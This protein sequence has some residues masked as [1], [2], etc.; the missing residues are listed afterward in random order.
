MTGKDRPPGGDSRGPEDI[1]G[2]NR[3]DV[4]CMVTDGAHADPLAAA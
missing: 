3:R 2:G 4:S 1:G